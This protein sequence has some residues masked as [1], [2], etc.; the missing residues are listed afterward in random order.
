MFR[1]DYV[2]GLAHF[3]IPEVSQ[4][5]DRNTCH[6][7]RKNPQELLGNH[8]FSLLGQIILIGP[9]PSADY[10]LVAICIPVKPTD[11]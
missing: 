10:Y 6:W 9:N 11:L 3:T 2:Y 4:D 5:F 7:G 8:S 1:D